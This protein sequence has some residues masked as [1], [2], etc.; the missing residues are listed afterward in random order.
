M[1]GIAL[2]T[3]VSFA[4]ATGV[5]TFFAPCAFPLL[6]GYVGYYMQRVERE[7]STVAGALVRGVAASLGIL[8]TFAVLA[9]VTLAV[10]ETLTAWLSSLEVVVGALLVGLGTLTLSD[11]SFGWHASLPKRRSSIHGFVAFG[12]LYA[13]AATGC[14]APVFLGVVAQALTFP[15]Y[16]T[17]A[18]LSGYAA[19]MVFLMVGATVAIAVGIDAGRERLTVLSGRATPVAGIVLVL[20]GLAQIGLALFVYT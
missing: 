6:P 20:A 5:G 17:I 13:V 15:I 3:A 12:A 1:S 8:A 11:R 7:R 9:V 19:G 18:V 10:G 14:L 2:A 4:F 16:G